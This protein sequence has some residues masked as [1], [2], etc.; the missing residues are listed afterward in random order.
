MF[1]TNGNVIVVSPRIYPVYRRASLGP[2]L[3]V[4]QEQGHPVPR[5]V[6]VADVAGEQGGLRVL[7]GDVLHLGG[8]VGRVP[9]GGAEAQQDSPGDKPVEHGR[10]ILK[11]F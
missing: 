8:Q 5:V 9:P 3:L 4:P 11:I 7:V 2:V 1:L 6:G 10:I